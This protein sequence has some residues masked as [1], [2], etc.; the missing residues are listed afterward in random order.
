MPDIALLP[1]L[2]VFFGIT[3]DELFQIPHEAEF[4]WCAGIIA[5]VCD[6]GILQHMIVTKSSSP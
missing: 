1:G 4:E 6:T 5:S 2:A 3:I